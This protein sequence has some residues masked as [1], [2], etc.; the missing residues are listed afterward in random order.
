MEK[1]KELL[2]QIEV[3]DGLFYTLNAVLELNPYQFKDQKAATRINNFMKAGTNQISNDLVTIEKELK[4]QL[5]I[6][7]HE[8]M[9]AAGYNFKEEN[10]KEVIDMLGVTSEEKKEQNFD[11]RVKTIDTT[12]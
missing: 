11:K 3:L 7:Q 4:Q 1:E 8:R 12:N 10:I 5:I 2:Y 9:V 6:K